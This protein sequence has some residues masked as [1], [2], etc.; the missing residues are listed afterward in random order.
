MTGPRKRVAK[1]GLIALEIIGALIAIVGGLAAFVLWRLERGPVSLGPFTQSAALAIERALPPDHS[2]SV[3]EASLIKAADPGSYDLVLDR[4]TIRGPGNAT[5]AD[6]PRIALT[7]SASDLLHRGGGPS[8]IV[9]SA[10]ILRIERGADKRISLAYA[11]PGPRKSD[12]LT[13]FVHNR[14]FREAFQS[15][16]LVDAEVHF[17]DEVSGRAWRA[18]GAE[19]RIYRVEGGYAAQLAGDFDIDG[20]PESVILDV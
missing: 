12:L 13:E 11:A 5:V 19:A 1:I 20:S 15:A 3:G 18:N 17:V 6:I 4:V 7:F 9:V 16:E 10:A 14:Y 8:R 2:A